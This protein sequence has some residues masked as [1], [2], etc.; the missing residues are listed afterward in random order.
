MERV[1]WLELHFEVASLAVVYK[2]DWAEGSGDQEFSALCVPLQPMAQV[3]GA[4]QQFLW[5]V[6]QWWP[7]PV[8]PNVFFCSILYS[9]TKDLELCLVF[10]ACHTMLT[11]SMDSFLTSNSMLLPWRQLEWWGRILVDMLYQ[12][13]VLKKFSQIDTQVQTVCSNAFVLF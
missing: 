11:Q 8:F 3:G 4:S 12:F 1:M 9:S 7:C 10:F 2:I 6:S 5:S 13:I